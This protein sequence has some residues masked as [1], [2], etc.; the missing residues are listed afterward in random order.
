MSV[1]TT[2]NAEYVIGV[3]VG[4]GSARAGLFALDGEMVSTADHPLQIFNP[5]PNHVEQSSPDIWHAVCQALVQIVKF[6]DNQWHEPA[7]PL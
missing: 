2:N 6:V 7:P 1:R 5:R 4:T 3:D